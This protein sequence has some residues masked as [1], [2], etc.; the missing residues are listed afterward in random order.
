MRYIADTID[1][2]KSDVF[3]IHEI[4]TKQWLANGNKRLSIALGDKLLRKD[5]YSV[6]WEWPERSMKR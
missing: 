5:G 1:H 4:D 2:T 6:A 3:A